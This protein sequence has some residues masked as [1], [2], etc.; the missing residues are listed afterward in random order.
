M[1]KKEFETICNEFGCSLKN[2][3][4]CYKNILV[5]EYTDNANCHLACDKT[6][7]NGKVVF[8]PQTYTPFLYEARNLIKARLEYVKYEIKESRK[9]KIEE[10]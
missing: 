1:T 6:M 9:K 4:A 2:N 5:A 10:L 3:I 8:E 7:R